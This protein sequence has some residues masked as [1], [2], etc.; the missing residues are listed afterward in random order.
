MTG[1]GE[2]RDDTLTVYKDLLAGNRIGGVHMVNVTRE[3]YLAAAHAFLNLDTADY[4]LWGTSCGSACTPILNQVAGLNYV[5]PTYTTPNNILNRM[6]QNY[7]SGNQNVQLYGNIS[8]YRKW[9]D[10]Q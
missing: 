8:G 10:Q 7:D 9:V 6:I 4:A 5:D 1:P 2:I 3:Q